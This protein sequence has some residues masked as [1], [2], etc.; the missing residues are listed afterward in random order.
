MR[1]LSPSPPAAALP[2]SGSF[3]HPTPQ[4]T[5]LLHNPPTGWVRQLP[6]CRESSPP[7][8]LS[9][10]LLL[11]WMNV[12]SLCPWLLDFHTARFSVSSG[13]FLFL[14]CCCPSFG[15][16]GRHSVSTYTSI[17]ARSLSHFLKNKW[18]LSSEI[19]CSFTLSVSNADAEMRICSIC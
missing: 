6:P 5:T 3:A 7:S 14:N 1:S 11:V 9:P 15:C 16:V 12:S 4:S 19:S 17:L 8:C 2:A 18:C 10:P 13:C